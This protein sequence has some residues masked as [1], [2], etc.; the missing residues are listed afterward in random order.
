MVNRS[1]RYTGPVPFM[2]EKTQGEKLTIYSLGDGKPNRAWGDQKE[3]K[4]EKKNGF[5]VRCLQ[6]LV[7]HSLRPQLETEWEYDSLA[8]TVFPV[9]PPPPGLY[10]IRRNFSSRNDEYTNLVHR[11]R[12]RPNTVRPTATTTTSKPPIRSTLVF[13]FYLLKKCKVTN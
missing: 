3:K 5:S 2:T 13:T 1:D 11:S 4:E 10:H 7:L 9:H 8:C 6:L 12:Q